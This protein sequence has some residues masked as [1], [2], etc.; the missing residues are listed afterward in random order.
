MT[1]D[2][3]SS[4]AVPLLEARALTVRFGA[5]TALDRLDLIAPPGEVLAILGPNG[6]GKTTFVRNVAT[7]LRPTSGTLLVKGHDGA[8]HPGDVRRV[9]GLAGQFAAVDPTMSG[10]ENLEMTARLFGHDKSGATRAAA[11]V[12]DQLELTEV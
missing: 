8:R 11:I 10:R 12:I 1:P 3:A 7:L 2:H 4:A 5:V 9:I 6:A